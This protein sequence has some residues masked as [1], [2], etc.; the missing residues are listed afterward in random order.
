MGGVQWTTDT[1][2]DV[3]FVAV[4]AVR[5]DHGFGP[6]LEGCACSDGASGHGFK[7]GFIVFFV[8]S[9][10][11][12]IRGKSAYIRRGR[13]STFHHC[14]SAYREVMDDVS[15]HDIGLIYTIIIS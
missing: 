12:S 9:S 14:F 2:F 6:G 7:V 10:S 8:S 15:I 11:D 13:Q 1:C 5:I 4:V 3:R